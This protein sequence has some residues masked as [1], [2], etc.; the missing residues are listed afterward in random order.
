[1]LFLMHYKKT[2]VEQGNKFYYMD[3]ILI[4]NIFEIIIVIGG[5]YF[6]GMFC[7]KKN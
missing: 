2:V 5:R 1:M 3:K 4:Q 7:E 6:F